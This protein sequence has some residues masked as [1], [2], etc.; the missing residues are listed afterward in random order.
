MVN[1][2]VVWTHVLIFEVTLTV[3]VENVLQPSQSKTIFVLC[4]NLPRLGTTTVNGF[5]SVSK[6]L[7]YWK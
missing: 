6:S 1:R 7:L 3:Y 5:S 2:S 4:Q